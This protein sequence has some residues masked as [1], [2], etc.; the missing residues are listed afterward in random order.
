MF[1]LKSG[2]FPSQWNKSRKR[3]DTGGKKEA[4]LWLL[5]D[6]MTVNKK[7]INQKKYFLQEVSKVTVHLMHKIIA[8]PKYQQIII[9][10]YNWKKFSQ[11]RAI[12]SAK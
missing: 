11:P 2:K 4:N 1:P 6:G 3:K 10:K 9:E 7:S 8:F 12:K 5:A